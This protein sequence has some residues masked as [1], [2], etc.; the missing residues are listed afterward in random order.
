MKFR[1]TTPGGR[2]HRTEGEE[3]RRALRVRA[4]EIFLPVGQAVV[5]VVFVGIIRVVGVQSIGRFPVARDAIAVG[6]GIGDGRA[7]RGGS[8]EP[9]RRIVA[10][11]RRW[12]VVAMNDC[13]R[14]QLAGHGVWFP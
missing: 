1:F 12:R 6:V 4:G 8:G 11:A 10:E 7:G 5:I 2:G 14:W 9:V 13:R 3:A